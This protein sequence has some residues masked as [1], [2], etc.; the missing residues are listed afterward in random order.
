MKKQALP[1]LNNSKEELKEILRKLEEVDHN[2]IDER[3]P[4]QALRSI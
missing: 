3:P 1:K 4:L 2:K